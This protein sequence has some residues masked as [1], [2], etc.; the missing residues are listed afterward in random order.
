MKDLNNFSFNSRDIGELMK[1][2]IW[3]NKKRKEIFK[4]NTELV[5]TIGKTI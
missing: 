1:R 2:N 4:L 3:L 5:L